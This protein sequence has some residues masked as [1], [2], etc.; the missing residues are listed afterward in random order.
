LKQ[1][2]LDPEKL[3]DTPQ[4]FVAF[5][6]L[7]R[8]PD[9]WWGALRAANRTVGASPALERLQSAKSYSERASSIILISALKQPG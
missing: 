1:L 2:A 4:L 8:L 9:C 6:H 7:E 5:G 3:C